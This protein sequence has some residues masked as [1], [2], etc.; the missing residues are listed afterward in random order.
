MV[1]V[2]YGSQLTLHPAL[3]YIQLR[4]QLLQG[5]AVIPKPGI[6]EA[7]EDG[8]I[9]RYHPLPVSYTHLTLPTN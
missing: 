1:G 6:Q 7:E 5:A 9:I 2:A 4:A 3:L 8:G